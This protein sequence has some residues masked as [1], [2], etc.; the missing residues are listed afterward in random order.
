[1]EQMSYTY[2]LEEKITID[3]LKESAKM[4]SQD[5]DAEDNILENILT[6]LAYYMLESDYEAFVEELDED[7]VSNEDQG[8]Y[9]D[10]TLV[11]EHEDGSATY[12]FEVSPEQKEQLVSAGVSLMILKELLG[13]ETAGEV[14]TWAMIGK[15]K[16]QNEPYE[17]IPAEEDYEE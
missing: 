1:M 3:S 16:D 6:V 10:V 13:A 5:Y 15:E 4:A 14:L 11:E 17:E 2:G 8:S 9:L 7:D 12:T